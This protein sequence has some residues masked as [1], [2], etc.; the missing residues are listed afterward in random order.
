MKL[1]DCATAPSPRRV[2]IFLAE[3][4]LEIPCVAVD[5]R[6][7]EHLCDAFRAVNPYCTV[8]VLELDDG[9]TLHST[10]AIWRYI[11]EV[12]PDPPLMGTNPEEK[13]RI[14]DLQWHIESDGFAAIA[15]WLRNCAPGMKDRALPGP[16]D[17][18][19]IPQLA[20]RGRVRAQ[21]FLQTLDGLAESAQPFLCGERFSVADIDAL[22]AVDFAR[23]LHLELPESA[24]AARLWYNRVAARPSTRA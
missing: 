4:G 24:V 16:I 14:A 2:R 17:Y 1:Y 3:K 20:E 18:A 8:P 15:E 23:R 10:A 7:G 22:V 6:G 12:S 11:E 9:T 19:Q 21:A 13:A 5:L